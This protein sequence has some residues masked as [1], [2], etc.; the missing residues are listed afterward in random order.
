MEKMYVLAIDQGT[1][2]SRAIL[3]NREGHMVGVAQREFTQ[4]FPG[5]AGWSTMPWRSGRPSSA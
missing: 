1:T 5:R 2:S 3:F 4:I